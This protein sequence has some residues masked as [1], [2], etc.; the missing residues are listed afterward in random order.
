MLRSNMHTI[1]GGLA[2]VAVGIVGGLTLVTAMPGK[3][4][5]S[6]QISIAAPSV[7]AEVPLSPAPA[8]APKPD[9]PP[10]TVAV[11]PSKPAA[12][13]PVVDHPSETAAKPVVAT[14]DKPRA[15]GYRRHDD[16]DDDDDDD[17]C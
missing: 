3:T 13:T 5:Q 17:V 14:Q 11:Q 7:R 8:M 6:L 15:R 1:L 12:P 4:E 2:A 16:D 9:L 10:Q